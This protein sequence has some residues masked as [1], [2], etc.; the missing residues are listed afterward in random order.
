ME[1]VYPM[2]GDASMQHPNDSCPCGADPCFCFRHFLAGR[3][4]RRPLEAPLQ[5]MH[6]DPVHGVLEFPLGGSRIGSGLIRIEATA[7]CLTCRTTLAVNQGVTEVRVVRC[8]QHPL[9]LNFPDPDTIMA[10]PPTI[11]AGAG[12]IVIAKT[13]KT[14][15]KDQPC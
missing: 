3:A 5:Q 7:S 14:E 8:G 6:R 2:I 4:P 12:G 13:D 15:A 11:K 9:S 1:R 10:S